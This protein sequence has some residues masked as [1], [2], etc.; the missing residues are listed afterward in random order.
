[1]STNIQPD[2]NPADR[3]LVAIQQEKGKV[4]ELNHT[5]KNSML[6]LIMHRRN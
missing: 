1:M 6:L 2:N 5:I 3:Y 4:D